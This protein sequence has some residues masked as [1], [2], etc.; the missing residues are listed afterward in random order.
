MLPEGAPGELG[1]FFTALIRASQA[2]RRERCYSF[3]LLV[4]CVCALFLLVLARSAPELE[5]ERARKCS[6][7]RVESLLCDRA[8]NGLAKGVGPRRVSK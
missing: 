3:L 6:K 1:N 7:D 4:V 8:Q 5:N 2:L